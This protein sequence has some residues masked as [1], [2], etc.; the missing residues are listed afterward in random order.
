MEEI[1]E[2]NLF[3]AYD[4]ACSMIVG[5]PKDDV[6]RLR[7]KADKIHESVLC[8]IRLLADVCKDEKYSDFI[9]SCYFDYCF[10][11]LSEKNKIKSLIDIISNLFIDKKHL[12]E[13]DDFD[14]IVKDELEVI[15]NGRQ[16]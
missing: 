3:D 7:E 12:R 1:K 11:F 5:V 9:I 16:N 4:K 8:T 10:E 13:F 15:K 14:N 2:K 6:S